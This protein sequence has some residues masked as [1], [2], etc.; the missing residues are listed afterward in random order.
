M[1]NLFFSSPMC[2][3]VRGKGMVLRLWPLSSILKI[4]LKK[5]KKKKGDRK[6]NK[7]G[8]NITGDGYSFGL[9][10]SHVF[11]ADCGHCLL[12]VLKFR[13]QLFL[14]APY[15]FQPAP[16]HLSKISKLFFIPDLKIQNL[17]NTI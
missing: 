4:I 13:F 14:S 2:G 3:G 15:Q 12:L 16:Y 1:Q 10:F 7:R 6:R 11:P 5:V 9:D 17:K 8:V